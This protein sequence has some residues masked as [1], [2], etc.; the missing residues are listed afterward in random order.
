MAEFDVTPPTG[1]DWK[2]DDTPKPFP[3][4]PDPPRRKAFVDSVT[5]VLKA[6]GLMTSNEPG[7][8]AVDVPEDFK[9]VPGTVARQGN[10]WVDVPVPV[11]QHAID[12]NTAREAADTVAADNTLPGSIRAFAAAVRRIL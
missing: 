10:A 11:P 12:R 2:I 1:K 5:G 6:H 3:A 4:L 7:D 9:A 8:V